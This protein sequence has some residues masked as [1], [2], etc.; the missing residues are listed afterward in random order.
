MEIDPG[1]PR[2]MNKCR[3]D[4]GSL[5]SRS[6]RSTSF[7]SAAAFRAASSSSR[8]SRKSSW[9]AASSLASSALSNVIII[10]NC[11]RQLSGWWGSF[12]L[13]LTPTPRDTV[14]AVPHPI[15]VLSHSLSLFFKKKRRWDSGS[16]MCASY[17][18]ARFRS[19]SSAS[20]R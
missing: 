5:R 14:V 8:R 13:L 1:H 3:W 12:I 2:E 17:A 11:T 10:R 20:L 9:S 16:Y 4:S 15:R 19:T 6:S 18:A 7:P